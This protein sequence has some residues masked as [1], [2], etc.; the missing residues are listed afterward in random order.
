MRAVFQERFKPVLG[1]I[2]L[3]ALLA[4]LVVMFGLKGEAIFNT[5]ILIGYMVLL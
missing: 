4:T 2:Q 5:P 1:K 3:T